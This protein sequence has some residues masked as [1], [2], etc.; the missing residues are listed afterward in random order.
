MHLLGVYAWSL[1]AVQGYMMGA[2]M[3]SLARR[4]ASIVDS[5]WGP[6]F[7]VVALVTVLTVDPVPWRSFLILGLVAVWGG[8]LSTYVTA[9]NWG[10]GE[11]WRYRKW[12]EQAGQSFWW[13]SYF[14]VFV[15]QGILLVV[16]SSPIIASATRGAPT[17]PT[18]LDIAGLL[19]WTFGLTFE[20]VGDAQLARFK[21]DPNHRGKVFD[22]G[23]W[24][25]TRHPNYFGETVLWWGIFL[26]AV[27]SPITYWS[28]IGPITITF[29][30]L[31]V[32]GVR[33][34]EKG[35]TRNKP[36]YE[37]YIRRTSAFFP[38]PP[39]KP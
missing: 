30:L 11:D 24:K 37:E 39:R 15:L 17:H 34:L 29:L 28:V 12:R 20:A 14:K 8:R 31:R 27:S 16:V 38:W 10:K 32:S 26:I 2:W 22:R 23:L 35:L 36:G 3:L 21:K 1:V 4:N 6:G 13:R 25:Y 19:L 18:A 5:F 7:I 33:L 9:R